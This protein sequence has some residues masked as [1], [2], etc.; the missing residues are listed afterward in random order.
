MRCVLS[1]QESVGQQSG[2]GMKGVQLARLRARRNHT[3]FNRMRFMQF[4][5]PELEAEGS[6]LAHPGASSS[7]SVDRPTVAW[8][9]RS[10]TDAST[11]QEG[12]SIDSPNEVRR[13]EDPTWYALSEESVSQNSIWFSRD[14]VCIYAGSTDR[15]Q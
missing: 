12:A 15:R 11:A 6:A 2:H 10:R 1:L 5:D 7:A 3:D 9:E 13:A 14:G 4:L 8:S